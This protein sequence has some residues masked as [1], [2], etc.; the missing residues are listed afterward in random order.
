MQAIE[1]AKERGADLIFLFVADSSFAG[2]VDKPLGAALDDE[3]A[4]LGRSL[5]YIAQE[6]ARE[7]GVMAQAAIRQGTV[8]QSIEEYVRKVNASTLVV[9]SP[10]TSQVPQAFT[11]E[12]LGDFATAVREAT[13]V[14]V[15]VA[16]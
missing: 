14:E 13:G 16:N 3:L 5:L 9:G 11:T 8:K 4:R 2:P 6:R 12:E 7:Q 10:Q 15:V 1:L